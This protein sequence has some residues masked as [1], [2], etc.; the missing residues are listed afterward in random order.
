M[1]LPKKGNC[2]HFLRITI[3]RERIKERGEARKKEKKEGKRK[4]GRKTL[5]TLFCRS[6]IVGFC[7]SSFTNRHTLAL[8]GRIACGSTLLNVSNVEIFGI[9]FKLENSMRGSENRL[10]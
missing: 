10:L 8:L 4:E 2:G 3:S 9:I 6:R 1:L 7:G 5:S